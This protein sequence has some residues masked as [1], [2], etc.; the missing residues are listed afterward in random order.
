[1]HKAVQAHFEALETAVGTTAIG[2]DRKHVIASR[3]GRLS[4]LYTRFGE[5]NESRYF[6]EINGLV[7]LL[8]K[9]LEACPK[10]Q[11]LDPTFREK[12]NRLHEQLGLPPLRLKPP[13]A[14]PAEKK[15]SKKRTR[16]A[17]RQGL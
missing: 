4:G 9:E 7:Q 15:A 11:K 3:I 8:L 5:A 10:A 16:V 6:D 14:P 13:P 12:L 2:A 17:V 1:M